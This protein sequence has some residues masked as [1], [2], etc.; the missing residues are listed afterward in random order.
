MHMPNETLTI[1]PP[2]SL[3]AVAG[4]TLQMEIRLKEDGEIVEREIVQESDLTPHKAEVWLRGCLR[5]GQ[6]D[7]AMEQCTFKVLPVGDREDKS[8]SHRFRMAATLPAGKT[9]S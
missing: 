2:T 7:V 1:E 5:Q 9:V 6:P 4:A 8:A 3:R